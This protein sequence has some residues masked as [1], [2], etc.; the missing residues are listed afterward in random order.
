M[1]CQQWK[2]F[3]DE[4][5][6]STLMSSCPERVWGFLNAYRAQAPALHTSAR[7]TNAATTLPTG[8]CAV[9]VGDCAGADPAAVTGAAWAGASGFA[10]VSLLSSET[11]AFH[12]VNR[13]YCEH[14]RHHY[15]LVSLLYRGQ[16]NSLVHVSK[17]HIYI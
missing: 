8:E 2:E 4:T 1:G 17:F 13:V 7:A 12:H 6:I 3:E 15:T 9:A 10:V 16:R 11:L 14:R 5:Q